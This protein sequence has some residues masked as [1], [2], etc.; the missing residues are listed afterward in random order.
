MRLIAAAVLLCFAATGA[1]YTPPESDAQWPAADAAALGWD[2]ARLDAAAAKVADQSYPGITSLLVAA[3]GRL[4]YEQY[5]NGGS[6]DT[7]ND[8]RSATKT[9]TALLLGAAVDRGLIKDEQQRVY[10]FFR[11]KVALRRLDARRAAITLQDLL[12]MSAAWECDDENAFSTGNEERM[13]LSADWVQFVLDLPPRGYAPWQSR[14]ADSPY[15][16]TF[17]YCTAQS[18][19]LGAV[20]ERAA[21]QPLAQFA[22]AVLEQPLGIDRVQWN[23]ASEGTGMGGGGTRYRARDIARIGELL[24]D[25]GQWRGRQVISAAWITAMLTPRAVPREAVEYGY[26]LWRFRF[27]L[28]GRDEWFWAMSGN[29]GNYVFVS[30]QRGLVA[31]ITSTAYNQRESHRRSQEIF[32]D[33]V[34]AAMPVR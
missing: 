2:T 11:D 14:P 16:R 27:P 20:I 25:G 9:V 6:R 13:Y 28:Q 34:L 10:P 32:R 18:F 31:V 4:V 12:T 17:S 29:G 3:Q 1:A 5:F 26:Q 24:R 30:P 22:R 19:L 21:R 7:L 23:R 33:Y 15:G 8:M